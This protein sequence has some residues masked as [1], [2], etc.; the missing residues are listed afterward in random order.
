MSG[1]LGAQTYGTQQQEVFLG[2][3][4]GEHRD[5]SD[6]IAKEIDEEVRRIMAE[7]YGKAQNIL[8]KERK[9][10]DDIA[11]ALIEHETLS[12]PEFEKYF[13][14]LPKPKKDTAEKPVVGHLQ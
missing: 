8:K 1:K 10:L 7:A 3:S 13:D 5:Y 11:A 2:K 14:D 12:G 6:D 9:R 4:M